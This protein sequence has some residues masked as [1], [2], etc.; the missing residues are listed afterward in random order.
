LEVNVINEKSVIR[1]NGRGEQS[2][3]QRRMIT[4][5]DSHSLDVHPKLDDFG[6]L[7]KVFGQECRAALHR[8]TKQSC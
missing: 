7:L 4:E 6:N 8:D 2:S 5:L 3:S 1:T